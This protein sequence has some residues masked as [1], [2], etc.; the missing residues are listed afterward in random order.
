MSRP[1]SPDEVKSLDKYK[2][3]DNRKLQKTAQKKAMKKRADRV[4]K[5]RDKLMREKGAKVYRVGDKKIIKVQGTVRPEPEQKPSR[6]FDKEKDFLEDERCGSEKKYQ[7]LKPEKVIVEDKVENFIYKD[8]EEYQIEP[9]KETNLSDEIEVN[10]DNNSHLITL[11][12]NL[13]YDLER[14]V[15]ILWVTPVPKKDWK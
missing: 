9:T 10:S 13:Q 8:R 12:N 6:K 4:I 11:N 14:D 7:E 5:A 15:Y 2:K 3:E 1:K